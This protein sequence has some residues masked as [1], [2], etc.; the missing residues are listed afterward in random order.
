MRSLKRVLVEISCFT[1][2]KHSLLLGEA[3]PAKARPAMTP[4][5]TVSVVY[6][7]KH[8]QLDTLE[9]N[10]NFFS[11]HSS[12]YERSNP[13]WL[14]IWLQTFPLA[15]VFVAYRHTLS[16]VNSCQIINSAV[17]RK[18]GGGDRGYD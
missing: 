7:E 14:R 18:R 5:L 11:Q 12:R 17:Q 6:V 1:F 10:Y 3:F 16:D 8:V 13:I 2:S 4:F 9:P 15:G